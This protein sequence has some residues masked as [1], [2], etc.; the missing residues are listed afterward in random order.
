MY[1][2]P[3]RADISPNPQ[4][5]MKPAIKASFIGTSRA[6]VLI[7]AASAPSFPRG[8]G[9]WETRDTVPVCSLKHAFVPALLRR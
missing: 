8:G 9:A 2:P 3:E 5:H 7:P 1:E 6:D 4:I